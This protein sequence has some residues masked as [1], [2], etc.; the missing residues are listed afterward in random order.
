MIIEIVLYYFAGEGFIFKVK[1]KIMEIPGHSD[2]SI[3]FTIL[4]TRS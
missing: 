2:C 3:E 4:T 1:C